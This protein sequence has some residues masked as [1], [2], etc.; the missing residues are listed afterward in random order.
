MKKSNL[1]IVSCNRQKYSE[2][3]IHSHLMYLSDDVLFLFDGYLPSS[4]SMDKLQ[5]QQR[6][7]KKTFFSVGRRLS[8][9][10]SRL[11]LKKNVS[12]VLAEYGPSG[13]EMMEPCRIAK[14]PM[15]VHFH[16]YDAYR[17]DVLESYGKHY[18]EMFKRADA[19]VVVSNNM[20]EQIVRLGCPVSKIH[21]IPYGVN[22]DIFLANRPKTDKIQFVSC[23]RF[24]SK[25]GPFYTIRAFA[26]VHEKYPMAYLIMIGDG[27][28]LDECKKLSNE[29]G[30]DKCIR[31][32]GKLPQKDISE[33]FSAS[34]AFLQHSMIDENNDSEG[35]PLV[36]IEA[37]AASL[38][39]IST[40]HAGIPDLIQDGINGF[41]VNEKDTEAMAAKMIEVIENPEK[42]NEMAHNLNRLVNEKYTMNI[43]IARLKKLLKEV[44][45]R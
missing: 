15:V 22:T 33:I 28:L 23:G 24:V 31:F 17:K 34:T 30:L 3:F 21:L 10:I 8:E 35:L 39:V 32:T 45:A 16:G 42:A 43:Y 14:V 9:S 40:F 25:K 13:V 4:Y 26:K 1:A 20:L 44:Q 11:L 27:E 19:V 38:P 18:Q 6:I 2:T 5:T 12:V 7:Q 37:G 29:L 41:L 36:L